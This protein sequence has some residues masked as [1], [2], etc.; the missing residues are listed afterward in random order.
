[1]IPAEGSPQ[2]LVLRDTREAQAALARAGVSAVGMKL[3]DKRAL[4]RAVRVSGLGIREV[5]LLK[6][7]LTSRGGDVAVS[8][9]LFQWLKENGGCLLM[10]TLAQFDRLLPRLKG[11]DTGLHELADSIETAL[12]NHS[13]PYP[14]C[15]PALHLEQAPLLMGI[16]NVTP[17]SFS[18]G[19]EYKDVDSAVLSGLEMVARGAALVDIGGESSRPGSGPVYEADELRRVMPVI[20]ALAR[21]LH[22]RIS[23]DTCKARVAAE[24]LAAGVF[25]V[26]DISALRADREMVAVVRDA[27]CPVILMHMQGAPKT[28]QDTPSYQDVVGEVYEFFIERLNWA[29]DNGVKEENLLIDPGIGFGKTTAHNLELLH[30]LEAFKSLGR[31]IVVGA[32]RKRFLGEL[33]GLESPRQRDRATAVTT[34]IAVLAGA[35]IVRVHE[36]TGNRE[37]ALVARAVMGSGA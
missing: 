36:V 28:M 35:H 5:N 17:D 22:G 2:V 20:Q 7:E 27:D 31:P 10:G 16:L 34:T 19:G 14:L 8:E 29:I 33:L 11:P 21:P 23:I 1:M 26:N 25:M 12:R 9:D 4:F 37:A 6:Q 32:S 30:N 24:A 3:M 13:E 18:D 15:H